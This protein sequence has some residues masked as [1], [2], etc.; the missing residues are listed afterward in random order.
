MPGSDNAVE[1]SDLDQYYAH[2]KD[3]EIDPSQWGFFKLPRYNFAVRKPVNFILRQADG[4]SLGEAIGESIVIMGGPSEDK[5]DSDILLMTSASATIVEP[6]Q[7]IEI[8]GITLVPGIVSSYTDLGKNGYA[9]YS[10]FKAWVKVEE[11][12]DPGDTFF[13]PEI[14]SHSGTPDGEMSR[15]KKSVPSLGAL[16]SRQLDAVADWLAEVPIENQVAYD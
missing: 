1:I 2:I 5:D 4:S 16:C 11:G 14:L 10:G 7:A 3:Q 12:K 8:E 9:G 13:L 15:L 6:S